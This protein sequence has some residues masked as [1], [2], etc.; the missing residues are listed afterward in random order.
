MS[1]SFKKSRNDTWQFFLYI[2][3]QSVQQRSSYQ[4]V[5]TR[6]AKIN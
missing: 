3:A 4:Q 2:K 1:K 6:A 5:D